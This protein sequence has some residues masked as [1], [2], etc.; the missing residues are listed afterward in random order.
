MNCKICGMKW[1]W[2]NLRLYS[3]RD[4]DKSLARPT[5]LSIIFS[6]QGTG[7]SPTGTDPENRVGDQDI[8]NP[9]RPDSSGLQVPC[10]PFPSC[11]G[12]GLTSTLVQLPE[13]R[14]KVTMN[15]SGGLRCSGMGRRITGWLGGRNV[16]AWRAPITRWCS[17]TTQVNGDLSTSSR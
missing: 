1:S 8:G 13:G 4:N 15:H 16:H 14:T 3:Y 12:W 9:G 5:S 6:V 10:G 11:S 2:A 17:A 7:G